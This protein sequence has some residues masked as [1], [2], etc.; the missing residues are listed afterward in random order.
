M[1]VVHCNQS[2]DI[3]WLLCSAKPTG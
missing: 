1:L 2:H 3:T